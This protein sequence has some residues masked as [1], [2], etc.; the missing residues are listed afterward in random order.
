MNDADTTFGTWLGER[1][2]LAHVSQR[3]LAQR[4][5]CS[6]ETV[7][8]IEQGR[9]CPS[10]A[11]V[12]RLAEALNLRHLEVGAFLEYA[13]SGV[14]S[15][16]EPRP[17]EQIP[18]KRCARP[19]AGNLPAET[20]SFIG[21]TQALSLLKALMWR[22]EVRLVTIVG[23][24]G[25][26]KTRL[27][28]QLARSFA[29]GAGDG[30]WFV[31]L[32][33]VPR[34]ELVADA[35]ASALGVREEPGLSVSRSLQDHLRCRRILLLLD[36]FEHV[37]PA[38][39]LIGDLLES[40]P[41]LKVLVTSRSPLNV[42]GEQVWPLSPLA[43]P[44]PQQISQLERLERN[45]AVRL[46]YE[47]ARAANPLFTLTH[48]NAQAVA[49]ICSRLD[50]LPLAIEL[51]AARARYIS[52][53][54]MPGHFEAILDIPASGPRDRP[55]RQQ[56]LRG[57]ISWSYEMLNPKDQQLF[58]RLAVFRGSWLPAAARAVCSDQGSS[59]SDQE[60]VVTGHEQDPEHE[61][62]D[63]H[64]NG[65]EVWDW[66]GLSSLFDKSLL[67]AK[68]CNLES[69]EYYAQGPALDQGD[70]EGMSRWASR[71]TMLETIREYALEQ[72]EATGEAEAIR[73]RHAAHYLRFVEGLRSD[74]ASDSQGSA[75]DRLAAEH[76]NL[77]AVLDW[78][79]AGGIS[80]QLWRFR[81]G[82]RVVE[83]LWWF[84]EVRGHFAEG[85]RRLARARNW[86]AAIGQ[87]LREATV[88][89][90][91]GR[92]ALFQ[93][94]YAQAQELLEGSLRIWQTHK[95]DSG[96][97]FALMALGNLALAEGD[98][99]LGRAR[100]E[101]ALAIRRALG[102]NREISMSL[103]ALGTEASRQGDH[104]RAETLLA[105]G[106]ALARTVGNS[107]LLHLLLLDAAHA[108]LARGST[109]TAYSLVDEAWVLARAIDY[110]LG[111]AECL[112]AFGWALAE[113]SP[114]H[115]A[116]L[117]GAASARLAEMHARLDPIRQHEYELQ[118]K[119]LR[120][121]L[122]EATFGA[123]WKSAAHISPEEARKAPEEHSNL[124]TS[125]SRPVDLTPRE[126]AV[127]SALAL[128][129]TNPQVADR[130][131]LSR[132]TVNA[133]LRS[134]YSKLGVATRSAAT[135]YALEHHLA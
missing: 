96:V 21:R 130:F 93:G 111:I 94:D 9:R 57:A 33:S 16:I 23:P 1:R 10:L 69:S 37:N 34:P 112:G 45:E 79:E 39:P 42:Y 13:R 100:Y 26:G 63:G 113:D 38:A 41:S 6:V 114:E 47:R 54:E 68:I 102:R 22:S 40:S 92:F 5:S 108:A 122:G 118:V 17:A 64:S 24:P 31:P 133:H 121:K 48:G 8:K 127:L 65:R 109:G 29:H 120:E 32:A 53:Q 103:A 119:A 124:R 91:G 30:A 46:F 123:L 19:P 51:A 80:K 132:H 75:L 52:P 59:I 4:A 71:F 76:D 88:L 117:F 56:T 50:G 73:T 85:R 74:L 62:G 70:A 20:T 125:H 77:K 66:E 87:P 128:G 78:C 36:N 7:K 89:W 3:E 131:T 83:A 110:K 115:S 95:S 90:A 44:G 61:H 12:K 106:V 81:L 126:L 84:W 98:A 60:S 49:E 18:G 116:R 99:C 86:A 104:A 58:R 27:S 72:L 2:R 107:H 101:E 11:L 14:A 67:D 129:L 35:I 82:L 25:V 28:L 134:I 135:R 15:S 55:D 43:L 97:A 105:E